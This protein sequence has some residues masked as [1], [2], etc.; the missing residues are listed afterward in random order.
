MVGKCEGYAQ[1][2]LKLLIGEASSLLRET[3]DARNNGTL[4]TPHAIALQEEL[5][6]CLRQMKRIT[7]EAVAV[8]VNAPP[9]HV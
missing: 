7:H 1:H 8:K 9:L 5:E 6:I 2:D 4:A 3:D